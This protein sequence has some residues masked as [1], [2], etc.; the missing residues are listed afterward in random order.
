MRGDFGSVVYCVGGDVWMIEIPVRKSIIPPH[1][2]PIYCVGSI[3]YVGHVDKVDSQISG[4]T[5]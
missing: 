5:I 3:G 4:G 1:L 2:A